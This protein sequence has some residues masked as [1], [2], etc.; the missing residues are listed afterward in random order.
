MVPGTMKIVWDNSPHRGFHGTYR[1]L[2][3]DD[4]SRG[5]TPRHMSVLGEAFLMDFFVVDLLDQEKA[6]DRRRAD[7]DAL[8]RDLHEKEGPPFVLVLTTINITEELF[9]SLRG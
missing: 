3:T 4:G 6:W 2:F 8:L 5:S 1:I 7:A 9:Q